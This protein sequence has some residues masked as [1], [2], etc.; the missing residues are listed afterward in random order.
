M[1]GETT[2]L[3]VPY[4]SKDPFDLVIVFPSPSATTTKEETAFDAEHHKQEANSSI[5][6]DSVRGAATEKFIESR[7]LQEA[8]M[9]GIN[10][11]REIL[12]DNNGFLT[13][14]FLSVHKDH[15]FLC[16]RIKNDDLN[17]IADKA[18]YSLQLSDNAPEKLGIDI[19]RSI[20]P[21]V[22]PAYIKWDA[23]LREYM[24]EYPTDTGVTDIYRSVDR[25]RLTYDAIMDH[26]DL[27]VWEQDGIVS[28][29][30][31]SHS[32]A[33]LL[34]LAN[35]WAN[36]TLELLFKIE[37]PLD[38]IRNYFGEQIAFYFAFSGFL[39]RSLLFLMPLAFLL[40]A[41]EILTHTGFSMEGQA[42]YF[43]T[44][45]LAYMIMWI[46]V[47]IQKWRQREA[48]LANKWGMDVIDISSVHEQVNIHFRG[49]FV[50]D[51]AD[52]NLKIRQP[53]AGSKMARRFVSP[54]CTLLGIGLTIVL[55]GLNLWL[56]RKL[57]RMHGLV[58]A[59]V[60]GGVLLTIQ[61]KAVDFVW[62]KFGKMLTALEQHKLERTHVDSLSFKTF[63]IRFVNTYGSFF[64]IAFV[65]EHIVGCPDGGCLLQLKG[66]LT[67][68]FICYGLLSV[69]DA[70]I[71]YVK[72]KMTSRKKHSEGELS[73]VSL[74]EA[75]TGMNEYTGVE[76]DQD[77][78]Q[79][80]FPLFFVLLFGFIFPASV[81]LAFF[82]FM[83]QVRCDAWKLVHVCARP[84]PQK[85]T[86]IGSWRLHALE[87]M[88][89]LTVFVNWGLLI[90][91]IEPFKSLDLETKCLMF[92][93]GQQLLI[94]IKWFVVYKIPTET[95][96]LKVQKVRQRHQSDCIF[97]LLASTTF[98]SPHPVPELPKDLNQIGLLREND[99]FHEEPLLI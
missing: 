41:Y 6:R 98:F 16:V 63:L 69:M 2:A 29:M 37:Q 82:A 75:Q 1:D 77:F 43:H 11:L 39:S 21:R 70:I 90:F 81:I 47:F 17:K 22:V 28:M 94:G 30:R 25:I 18:E 19:D 83:I 99:P 80:I 58:L 87:G 65:E 84:F 14:E 49:V 73:V 68:V 56:R 64:Y 9:N 13:K 12:H 5:H 96:G 44:C 10:L 4:A 88:S 60:V 48:E 31:P 95:E 51:L 89:Y 74:L 32:R 38:D 27:N 26:V 66:K 46:T 61:I 86:N 67:V 8:R 24:R 33:Q 71:P 40:Q 54:L 35:S 20:G 76:L 91:H 55:L 97:S 85:A 93:V 52:R 34:F 42:G 92:F 15:L 79:I 72:F 57:H 59:S 62:L 50:P 36:M 78:T 7:S 23:H 3:G 53:S 45:Y